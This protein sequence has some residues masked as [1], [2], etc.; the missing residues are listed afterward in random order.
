MGSEALTSRES[1]QD[2][3]MTLKLL[4]MGMRRSDFGPEGVKN[5]LEVPKVEEGRD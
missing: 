3:Q 1:S 2:A 5:C 4:L